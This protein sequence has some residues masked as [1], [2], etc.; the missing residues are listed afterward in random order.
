MNL[1]SKLESPDNIYRNKEPHNADYVAILMRGI[2]MSETELRKH[3]CC[4]TGHRP[5]KMDHGEKEIKPLLE[6]A[7]DEAIENGY[8][9]FI[10][11]M[12]MGV[13][14]WA[15]EIVL[16]RKKKNPN[17]HLICALPHPNFEKPRSMTEKMRY[18]KI[19]K[20]ADFV[21]E[22]NDHYFRA[23]YQVRN[24][25]MVDHSNLIIAM[26]NGQK[27]GTKNTI[28]YAKRKGKKIYNCIIF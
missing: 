21:K 19:I 8:V 17:L 5:D 25:W 12:A 27:G 4:F 20:K 9:T 13:D 1:I 18:N 3:R 23:C 24:E 22:I 2:N 11:G 16:E 15:A 6:K 7:I 10:T 28:D 26:F 14:I